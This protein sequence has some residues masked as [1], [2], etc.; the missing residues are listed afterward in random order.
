MVFRDVAPAS[1]R[2]TWE[3]SEDGG[4]SWDVRWEIAYTRQGGDSPG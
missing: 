1:F 2:W 3:I 4:A